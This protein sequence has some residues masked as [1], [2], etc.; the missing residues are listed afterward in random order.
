LWG[1]T[2]HQIA[3]F[4]A[5]SLVALAVLSAA[6]FCIVRQQPVIGRL[7]RVLAL[8]LA[9][10]AVYA[11]AGISYDVGGLS[12]LLSGEGLTL[13]A[14]R[15]GLQKLVAYAE[16]IEWINDA[17]NVPPDAAVMLVGEARTYHFDRRTL[18][19]TVFNDHPI[20]PALRLAR[21]GDTAGA[22]EALRVTGATHVLVNWS[23]LTRLRNQTYTWKGERIAG[24]LPDLDPATRQPLLDL[25]NAAG[26]KVGE[27]G[28]TTWPGPPPIRI[29]AVEIYELR[30]R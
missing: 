29:P 13:V 4:L 22:V 24:Y 6:G 30:Q 9:F 25:L 12:P 14:H 19:S 26:D 27:Y 15:T 11:Q 10:F 16:S 21:D 23:E 3:R 7:C 20:E 17:E 1:L 8:A 5:P 28:G 2:T 18:Y